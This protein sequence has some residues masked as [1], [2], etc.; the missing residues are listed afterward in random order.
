[1]TTSVDAAFADPSEAETAQA[2]EAGSL[3][4]AV[5]WLLLGRGVEVLLPPLDPDPAGSMDSMDSRDSTGHGADAYHVMV[6]ISGAGAEASY[7]TW[8]YPP[9]W[10]QHVEAGGRMDPSLPMLLWAMQMLRRKARPTAH[11]LLRAYDDERQRLDVLRAVNW[12]WAQW[13]DA[14][15]TA[16]HSTESANMLL[17][18]TVPTEDLAL[19]MRDAAGRPAAANPDPRSAPSTVASALTCA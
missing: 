5:V 3:V 16:G 6:A 2:L 1:M 15:R 13:W 19:L 4:D 9:D 12:Q 18:L 11:R 8:V 7:A 14:L 10:A 17:E